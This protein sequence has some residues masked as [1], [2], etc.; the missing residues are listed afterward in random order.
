MLYVAT[1]ISH[2][3]RPAVTEA[4]ARNVARS[5]PR[6][7]AVVCLAPG[8]A[9][10][11]PFRCNG[12]EEDRANGN[13]PERLIKLVAEIRD[14]IGSQPVDVVV[15]GEQGRRKKLLIADMDSTMI[16]EECIDELAA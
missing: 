11:I 14:I 6:A 3:A 8:V 13:K 12:T 5:L 4:L 10:D 1:L 2:P 16:G 7:G 15:Q 9:I